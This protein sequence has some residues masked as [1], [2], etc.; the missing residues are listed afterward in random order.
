[1]HVINSHLKC[2]KVSESNGTCFNQQV[3]GYVQSI[4]P[5]FITLIDL[6]FCEFKVA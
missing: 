2:C 6:M 1:M 3:I 5:T 4:F